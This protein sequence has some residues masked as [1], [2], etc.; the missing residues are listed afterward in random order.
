MSSYFHVLSV[1]CDFLLIDIDNLFFPRRGHY[2]FLRGK[3][4][5]QIIPQSV[6]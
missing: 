1:L 3:R 2:K 5:G 4:W 6:I